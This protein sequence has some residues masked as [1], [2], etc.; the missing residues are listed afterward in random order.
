MADNRR[1][2]AGSA[3]GLPDR[4]EELDQTSEVDPFAEEENGPDGPSAETAPL[5]GADDTPPLPGADETTPLPSGP[6][7]WSGRAAVPRP[8]PI[9]VRGASP[10]SF[11]DV[12][13]RADRRWWLPIVVGIVALLLIGVL[14]YGVWLIVRP[15]QED[16]QP[17][18]PTRSAVT[19]TSPSSRPTSAAPTTATPT[20]SATSA[21]ATVALPSLIGQPEATARAVLDRLGLIYRLD[22]RASDQA[23]GTVIETEPGAGT[24]VPPGALVTLVIAEAPTAPPRT[25]LPTTPAPPT[26]PG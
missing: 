3:G 4:G 26:S 12:E 9:A 22:F 10:T 6:A 1:D 15:S 7:S 13:D 21:T 19:T 5:P 8:Q 24:P 17:V 23:P 16:P 20:P 11:N 25:V 14:T 2:A 18:I